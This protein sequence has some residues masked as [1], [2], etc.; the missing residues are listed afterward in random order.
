[1]SKHRAEITSLSVSDKSSQ[2]FPAFSEEQGSRSICC[3]GPGE[4][5]RACKYESKKHRDHSNM[6]KYYSMQTVY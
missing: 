6:P 2:E 3:C 1:M 5:S 4:L